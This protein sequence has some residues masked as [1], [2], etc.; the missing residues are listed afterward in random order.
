MTTDTSALIV[1]VLELAERLGY[2]AVELPGEAV[3]PGRAAWGAWGAAATHRQL[4][5]AVGVLVTRVHRGAP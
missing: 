5:G 3:G 1:H 2:P 4:A